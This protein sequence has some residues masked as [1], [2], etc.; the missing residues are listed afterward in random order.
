MWTLACLSCLGALPLGRATLWEHRQTVGKPFD[1]LHKWC[2][3]ETSALAAEL[4]GPTSALCKRWRRQPKPASQE[5]APEQKANRSKVVDMITQGLSG[6]TGMNSPASPAPMSFLSPGP[7]SPGLM[8][9]SLIAVEVEAALYSRFKGVTH[10]YK[11]HARMLRSN[12]G[13]A[14]N[15]KLRD[16]VLSGDLPAEELVAM[17]SVDLAPESLREQR[18]EVQKQAM[19]EIV[20]ENMLVRMPS[21][22]EGSPTRN[23]F[24]ATAPPVFERAKSSDSQASEGQTISKKIEVEQPAPIPALEPPPT[25]FLDPSMGNPGADAGE[26]PMTPYAL[27]TPGVDEE[28]EETETLIQYL[29]KPVTI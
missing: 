18:R 15:Q 2:G 20:V 4:R 7:M 24:S 26:P 25:P 22:G 11:S 3:R 29:T 14:G 16:R 13:H 9:V 21:R 28:H 10:D 5:Q 12:L 27:M 6:I 1:R 19:K 23:A 17:D 8:P